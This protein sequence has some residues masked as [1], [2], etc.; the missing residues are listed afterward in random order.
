MLRLAGISDH[1]AR[2]LAATPALSNS[3]LGG[4]AAT[5]VFAILASRN[6][7]GNPLP[8]L[9]VAPVLP[10]AGV[11]TAYGPGVDPTYEVGASSPMRGMRLLM[12]RSIAVF[13]TTS[14]LAIAASFALPHVDLAAAGWILPSLALATV[15]LALSTWFSPLRSAA[16]VAAG[17]IAVAIVSVS[18]VSGPVRVHTIVAFRESGQVSLV[19]ASVI[20]VF[21][22]ILRRDRLDRVDR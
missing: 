9:I 5:L 2:L 16:I 4:I 17:W 1:T 3:W 7:T 12:I 13:A 11:A 18:I 14:I 10:L 20:A 8:F 15:C 21:V 19:V 22:L 6:P